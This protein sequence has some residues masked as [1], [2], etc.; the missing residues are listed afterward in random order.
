MNPKPCIGKHE[1]PFAFTPRQHEPLT[2]LTTI[3]TMKHLTPSAIRLSFIALLSLAGS[4]L[5]SATNYT[6]TA[7]SAATQDWTTTTNWSGSSI[8]PN[9]G[10]TTDSLIF[11]ADTTTALASGNNLITTNVPTALN[12]NVLTLNGLGPASGGA[13]NITIGS[14]AATWTLGGTTP[15]VNL[16]ALKGTS[17]LNYT[18]ATN[19]A[20]AGTTLFTG[21][22]TA[23]TFTF[24]G[25]ISGTGAGITKSGA[26][27]LTLSGSNSFD[28]KIAV[29]GGTL[30]Y[31]SVSALGNGTS[32][33][34]VGG[35]QT[36][37]TYSGVAAA[38]NTRD[39]NVTSSNGFVSNNS[40]NLLT[41]SG[42]IT[43]NNYTLTLRPSIGNITV[44]G[45]ITGTN[46]TGLSATAGSDPLVVTL[47]DA[48]NSF[49]SVTVGRGT[50]SVG[51]IADSGLNSALG[52]GTTITLGQTGSNTTGKLQFT[53]A[54]GGSS[55]RTITI[56][57]NVANTNGG[58]IENTV[59]GQTLTLSGNIGTAAGG[60]SAPTLQLIGAGKGVLSGAISNATGSMSVT[61]SGSGTWTLSGNSSYTG[62]T[63]ISSGT[64]L[65]NGNNST[66]TGALSVVGASTTL[67]GS[68]TT[69]GVITSTGTLSPGDGVTAIGSLH[70]AGLTLNT[71]ASFKFDLGASNSSDQLVLSGAFT[72][73]T[74][75]TYNF[76]FNSSGVTS[77][78]YTLLTFGSLA[79]GFT[80]G[81]V[82][83]FT[84][85]GLAGG[86]T[87]GTFGLTGTALTFTT[88]PEPA[89]WALLAFSLTTVMVMR[90]RRD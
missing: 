14:N 7:N 6:W 49:G 83:N 55:N 50:L 24:S 5:V 79:G 9:P 85:T 20:L 63:T 57:S 39:I 35:V 3:K 46:A 27:A 44:N 60:G 22:G 38:T 88:V 73:G 71:G 69:G 75:A 61:K 81:D 11:F 67:G 45:R 41:L 59:A 62:T 16:N 43:M 4:H 40:S 77:S 54:S 32:S 56:A 48:T 70:A 23:T 74:G 76:D 30:L 82:S 18:V 36:S 86:V 34:D 8:Y 90:R 89:T 33:I 47:T 64:L 12:M 58:I 29:S 28:G 87:S 17:G 31:T 19:L 15:T 51:S 25:G 78:T 1:Q 37:L 68:G 80:A 26:S 53:G 42:N 10:T 21:A 65:I 13:T 2:A 66:A 84:Y 52:A 72:K